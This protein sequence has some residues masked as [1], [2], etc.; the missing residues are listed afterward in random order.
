[1]RHHLEEDRNHFPLIY[2]IQEGVLGVAKHV[3]AYYSEVYYVAGGIEYNVVLEN[4]EFLFKGIDG[5]DDG[6]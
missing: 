3:H 2:I 1:M 6:L 5:E 4:D